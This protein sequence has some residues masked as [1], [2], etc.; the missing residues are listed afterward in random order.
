MRWTPTE[1]K[2]ERLL[3]DTS[4]QRDNLSV[5]LEESKGFDSQTR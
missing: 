3:I 2:I 4:T 1:S 5:V